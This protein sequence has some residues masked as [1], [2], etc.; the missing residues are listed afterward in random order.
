MK[1]EENT[2]DLTAESPPSRTVIGRGGDGKVRGTTKTT[3]ITKRTGRLWL[4]W[5]PWCAWWLTASL[6][7][8]KNK[9]EE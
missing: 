9:D 4:S 5:C 8:L 7:P 3:K 2:Q 1:D 6:A